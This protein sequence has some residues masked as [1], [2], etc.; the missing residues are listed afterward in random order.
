MK[1]AIY[2]AGYYGKYIYNEIKNNEYTKISVAFWID[3]YI[4]EQSIYSLPVYTEKNFFLKEKFKEV[5]AVV[6]GIENAKIA[7]DIALSLLM[8]EYDR[9][10]LACFETEFSLA[11]WAKVPILD[12]DGNFGPCVK[13]YKEVKP[14]LGFMETLVTNYCNLNCKSCSHFSNIVTEKTLLSVD[15]FETYLVELRKKVREIATFQLLGG[16]PLL[17]PEL[18]RFVSLTRKYFPGT[19]IDVV[20]NGLLI[21]KMPQKLIDAMI[22]N[23]ATLFISQY[24]PT[25]EKIGR[26][27]SFLDEKQINF[28]ISQPI[29]DF[30][31][32]LTY[33]EK[34]AEKAFAKRS[35]DGCICHSIAK[36]RVY[37][38]PTI[39]RLYAVQDFFNIHIE[40]DEL[41]S[42][43]LDIMSDDVDGWDM[44]KYFSAPT[45]ICRFC[46]PEC[47]ESLWETGQ[48]KIE[49]WIV[50]EEG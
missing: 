34:T 50:N 3:N 13:F 9:I 42:S 27:I 38:C 47:K 40:E 22:Q 10:Y 18:D 29:T 26:I 8:Q 6:I 46:C 23:N 14:K 44:L 15:E 2:G 1:I 49:D 21:L 43:S 30:E 19:H 5:D 35:K 16:E 17:H 25:R 12:K 28:Y 7:Q 48:P 37:V 41:K 4:N 11:Y 45:S 39:E 32:V 33:K 24:H 36:G 20:T 31:S